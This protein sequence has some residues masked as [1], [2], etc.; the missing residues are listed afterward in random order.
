MIFEWKNTYLF[1]INNLQYDWQIID[2]VLS[3]SHVKYPQFIYIQSENRDNTLLKTT[4]SLTKT[5]IYHTLNV[6]TFFS[7]PEGPISSNGIK[8]QKPFSLLWQNLKWQTFSCKCEILKFNIEKK[9]IFHL[10]YLWV[11]FIS[12]GKILYGFCQN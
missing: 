6:C 7:Y 8:N 4:K 10:N 2:W 3:D 1:L 12:S 9:N 11:L 5:S